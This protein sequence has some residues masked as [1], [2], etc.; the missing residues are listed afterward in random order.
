MLVDDKTT[1]NSSV[2]NIKNG[3]HQAKAIHC[4]SSIL[5]VSENVYLEISSQSVL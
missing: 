2:L 1:D 4:V 3:N 5:S